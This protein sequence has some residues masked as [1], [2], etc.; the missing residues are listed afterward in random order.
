MRHV[1]NVEL[2]EVKLVPPNPPLPEELPQPKP[3]SLL[4]TLGAGAL[5]AGGTYLSTQAMEMIGHGQLP[6]G[7]EAG[8]TALAGV[9][10]VGAYTFGW[11]NRNRQRSAAIDRA[12]AEQS[13]NR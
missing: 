9:A 8:F 1:E 6:A 11:R 13:G 4:R 5:S 10:A 3:Q 7:F 12:V 2:I